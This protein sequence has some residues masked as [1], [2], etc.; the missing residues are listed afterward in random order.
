MSTATPM[1]AVPGPDT[2]AGEI[3]LYSH[4][5]LLYW[6]PVWAAGF[7]MALWTY[8]DNY[9]MAL[10]PESTVVQDNRL[11]APEGAALEVPAVHMARSR[12]PGI[13]FVFTLLLAIY[14]NAASLRGPWALFGLAVLAALVLLFNWLEW[15][16]PL[17]RWFGMLR[18]HL[19]LGAYLTIATPLF[20]LWALTVFFFD[21]RTYAGFST[22]QVH[23]RDEL[24][25]SE[26]VYDTSAVTFEK[27][28]YDWLC[29]L[30]GFGA[31]DILVRVG[32]PQPTYY[33]LP[34][35]IRVGKKMRLIEERLRTRDVI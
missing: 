18:V 4:S 31:G 10:V 6:W 24:G 3:K 33:S 2:Q 20:F 23:I 30:V 35:V 15:W 13:V 32:G 28:P 34:N 5:P 7:V 19:N 11:L 14:L 21:R 8:F 27:E 9:H 17:H 16:S 1:K 22:G 26:K 12:W 25:D 29:F